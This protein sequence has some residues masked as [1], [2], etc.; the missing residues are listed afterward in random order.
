MSEVKMRV[1]IPKNPKDLLSLATS[2]FTK[3]TSDGDSSPLLLLKDFSWTI[4][5]PKLVTAEAKHQEAEKYKKLMETAYR[6]R[7]LI[8]A[9]TANI[10]RASR[11]ILSGINRENMKRLGDWGFTVEASAASKSKP[12]SETKTA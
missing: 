6:E 10:V 12:T 4:E 1:E 9:D 5:G 11:D 3:H 7:D 8:M 2:V